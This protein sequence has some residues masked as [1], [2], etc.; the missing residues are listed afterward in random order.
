MT[1]SFPTRESTKQRKTRGYSLVELV[2]SVGLFSI[3]MMLA[4]GAYFMMT[5]FSRDAQGSAI[6]VNNLA[7]ALEKMTRA[8]R[9]GGTYD[10]AGLGDCPSGAGT[11]SFIDVEGAEVTYSLSSGAIQETVDGD[12]SPLT[13]SSIEVTALTFYVTGTGSPPGDYA[14][15]HVTISVSGTVSTGPEKTKTFTVETG[16]TMRGT[17]L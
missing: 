5:S 8:I 1:Y 13:D 11:F 12:T 14:Q 4:S 2:V 6:G 3:I 10:C 16:A 17:D 15:P 9:T 7:F